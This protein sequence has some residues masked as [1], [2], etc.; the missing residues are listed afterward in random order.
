M[1]YSD[2]I[3]AIIFN[4]QIMQHINW[5]IIGCGSVTEV[6]SG[7]AF[8]KVDGSS[9][10]AVMRR[11]GQKAEDYAR[12]HHVD[13]WYD[14]AEK[15]IHDREVNAV[16]VATPPSSHAHYAILAMEAGKTVY[17]E[18]P[19]AAEYADCVAM[20]KVSVRTRMPLYVAYYRRFLPY[21]QKV[22]ELL[23]HGNLGRVLFVQVALHLPPRAEDKNAD[24]LPWRVDKDIAGGGYFYDLACH[25][26]DLLEWFFGNVQKVEGKCFNRAGLYNAEDVVFADI[27]YESGIPL[28]ASWCF[29]AEGRM[30]QDKITVYGSEASLEFSTFA[31]TPIRLIKPD[32]IVENQP[33]NPENIQYWFIRNMVEELQGIRPKSCNGESAAKTNRIMDIILGKL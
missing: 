28:T 32:I 11:H 23:E 15:L 20:N 1:D 26:I 10:V 18:K 4:V 12:R 27:L 7:P 9:L 16:Y 33:S 29:T 8:G 19:M 17:V 3:R 24:N 13:R 30:Q 5:G 21:F 25:Q 2:Y 31:F 14:N 22:R 6:K